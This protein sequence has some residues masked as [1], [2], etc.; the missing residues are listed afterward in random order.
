MERRG[1]L[2]ALAAFAIAPLGWL[3]AKQPYMPTTKLKLVSFQVPPG[4]FLRKGTIHC[5]PYH[6]ERGEFIGMVYDRVVYVEKL[7]NPAIPSQ[8]LT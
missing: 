5:Y 6:N 4:Y 1:F 7:E 2:G 8:P 3:K